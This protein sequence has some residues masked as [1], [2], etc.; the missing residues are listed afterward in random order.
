MRLLV[1][2]VIFLRL[3]RRTQIHSVN[4]IE[5]C[6]LELLVNTVIPANVRVN[7][8]SHPVL[9]EISFVLRRDI[10]EFSENG[11]I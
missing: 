4:T 2:I 5:F 7:L 6:S 3:I 9:Q 8:V 1:D 11:K 10:A